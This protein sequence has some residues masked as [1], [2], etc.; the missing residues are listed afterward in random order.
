MFYVLNRKRDRS[1]AFSFTNSQLKALCGKILIILTFF[2]LLNNIFWAYSTDSGWSGSVLDPII[3]GLSQYSSSIASNS[4]DAVIQ[5][6]SMSFSPNFFTLLGTEHP[7]LAYGNVTKQA[8]KESYFFSTVFGMSQMLGVIV[9]TILFFVNAIMI[10]IGR[11]NK[12]RDTPISLFIR[13]IGSLVSIYLAFDIVYAIIMSIDEIWSKFV[14]RGYT[15]I[16]SGQSFYQTESSRIFSQD[17]ETGNI[18][19]WGTTLNVKLN[20][21]W[22]AVVSGMMIFLIWKLIKSVFRLYMEVAERYFVLMVLCA[23]FPIAVSTYSCTTT[24]NIF[25]SYLRMFFCQAFVMLA[26]IAFMKFFFFV[27]FNGG[28]L[29]TL[30]NYI[31]SQA[32]V[33]VAQ[34]LDSYMMAMGLSVA[35]TGSGILGAACGAGLGFADMFRSTN[36]TRKNVGKT[37]LG[38]GVASNNPGMYR[39]GAVMGMSGD[40]LVR[41]LT[42]SDASFENAVA[43]YNLHN[44]QGF[45]VSRDDAAT[46]AAESSAHNTD[47][48]LRDTLKVNGVPTTD[49][50]KLQ[51]LG[52]SPESIVRVEKDQRTGAVTYND[53]DGGVATSYKGEMFSNKSRNQEMAYNKEIAGL[54]EKYSTDVESGQTMS[55]ADAA[56]ITAG[57]GDL[58][59]DVSHVN[60]DTLKSLYAGDYDT[61]DALPVSKAEHE[62]MFKE[63]EDNV[64]A[65]PYGLDSVGHSRMQFRGRYMDHTKPQA[66]DFF[67]DMYN[68]AQHPET[69]KNQGQTGWHFVKQDGEGFMVH[70][71]RHTADERPSVV[72]K[73]SPN[74]QKAKPNLKNPDNH[75][76]AEKPQGDSRSG[77]G[78]QTRNNTPS[79]GNGSSK[80]NKPGRD[81]PQTRNT[82]PS[83]GNGAPTNTPVVNEQAPVSFA[84]STGQSS[85]SST[86]PTTEKTVVQNNAP[87]GNGAPVNTPVVNEQAPVS[88]AD[89][90]GQSSGSSTAPTAEKTVVQNNAPAGNGVPANMPVVN[91][92]APVSFADSTGQS[93]GP[94][95]APTAENTVVQNNAPAGNGTPANTPGANEQI[96]AS[97]A[98][99]KM[100][101]QNGSSFTTQTIENPVIKNDMPFSAKGSSKETIDKRFVITE[102]VDEEYER[103]YGSA[104]KDHDRS[105]KKQD[106]SQR[107]K[108]SSRDDYRNSG[109]GKD[110]KGRKGGKSSRG[111]SNKNIPVDFDDY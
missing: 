65:T 42:P 7:Y 4:A 13:Y 40:T 19:M 68:I 73:V 108:S 50:E 71:N 97:F 63:G 47:N 6:L 110:K 91:E 106:K 76:N 28:W 72:G 9:A 22:M 18:I 55:E 35:Q 51:N 30:T 2:I 29:A 56:R 11:E 17:P 77:S 101:N 20:G 88:F 37:L 14:F 67:V 16:Y 85:G 33:K 59:T 38:M 69:L 111:P 10:V 75:I 90:M 89:S 107:D 8:V 81:N 74:L 61:L 87:A 43:R 32:F 48:W 41:G 25:F 49:I 103:I 57:L 79:G 15:S 31:C 52:I 98:D 5:L 94:S 105:T 26:N 21:I 46:P 83:G 64:D 109:K 23:F 82:T 80:G 99:T 96:T 102:S 27:L 36:N 44:A 45:T 54:A 104:H 62:K 70:D 34:R 78:S 39:A 95:T 84:D 92:Q 53:K 60:V 12:I 1:L 24:K 100:P 3:D 66:D 58:N 86:V 93:S